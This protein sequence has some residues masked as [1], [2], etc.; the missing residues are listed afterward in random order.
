[1]F[2]IWIALAAG[3][4]AMA[5]VAY[6]SWSINNKPAGTPRMIE[7]AGYIEEGTKTYIKR[8]YRT[9][10]IFATLAVVP[11]AFFSETSEWSQASYLAAYFL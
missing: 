5:T 9:I 7:I 8:Q 4:L 2:L 3:V 10:I 1:M 11:I 6:L